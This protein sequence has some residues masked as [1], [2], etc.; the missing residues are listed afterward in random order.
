M[1]ERR[2]MA[3]T[4]RSSKSAPGRRHRIQV[5]ST[6]SEYSLTTLSENWVCDAPLTCG[7]VGKYKKTR[8]GRNCVTG[9]HSSNTQGFLASG[10]KNKK[11]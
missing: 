8:A 11:G 2:L 3:Q 4:V 10:A 9:T 1:N 5:F 7:T 6:T